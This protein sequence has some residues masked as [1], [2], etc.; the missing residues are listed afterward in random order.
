MVFRHAEEAKEGWGLGGFEEEE[1]AVGVR[2]ERGSE[3]EIGA[4]G[5]AGD[6]VDRN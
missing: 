4:N 5:V 2:A 1:E 3:E 6:G